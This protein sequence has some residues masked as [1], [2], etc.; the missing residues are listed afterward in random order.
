MLKEAL[1]FVRPKRGGRFIDCTLGGGGYASALIEAVGPEGLVVAFDLDKKAIANFSK[2]GFKNAHL[3]N[4]SFGNLA[5]R[6]RALF[7]ADVLFDGIVMDLGLS[8]AQMDDGD[9]GFSFRFDASLDMSFSGGSRATQ[10]IVNHYEEGRLARIITDYGEERFAKKIARAITAARKDAPIT[11]AKQLAEII[12]MAIPERFRHGK[13]HPATKTF[14]ALRIETNGELEAL[15]KVLPEAISLLSPGGRL[16]I[17]SFHSLEDR[18]VK[19]FFRTESRDCLCPPQF[20]A[21][22]C[23]HSRSLNVINKKPI[24]PSEAEVR[25]N[26]RSRSAK[27]RVAEKI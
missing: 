16:A 11:N 14:Q 17:V 26:P 6:V 25:S 19:D 23:G 1:S 22:R 13:I 5:S 12:S 21:C 18:I 24:G 2:K 8:S 9:R 4:D 15:V 10:D 27:L 7:G 3:I 20:P